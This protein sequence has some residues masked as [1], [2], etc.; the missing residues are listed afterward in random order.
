MKS[1]SKSN[2]NQQLEGALE[3]L[4]LI[5]ESTLNIQESLYEEFIKINNRMNE[6]ISILEHNGMKLNSSG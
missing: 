1:T 3:K 5:D 2:K 4:T 6:I